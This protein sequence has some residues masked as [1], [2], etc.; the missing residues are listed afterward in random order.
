MDR[1]LAQEFAQR[2]REYSDWFNAMTDLSMRIP[3]VELGRKV[4]R[5][6]AEGFVQLDEVLFNP[7]RKEHPNF[8][9]PE[10]FE[11]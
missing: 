2:S 9:D 5:T 3:E 8:F 10:W 1:E 11:T 6:L 4:R 7:T